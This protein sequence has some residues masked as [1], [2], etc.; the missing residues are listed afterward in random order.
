MIHRE[1]RLFA[2]EEILNALRELPFYEGQ[3][4][5]A[6]C[7]LPREAEYA[8]PE[9]PMHPVLE[10]RL[11]EIGIERLYSHQATAFDLATAKKDIVVTTGTGSG[12][13][14]CYNLPVLHALLSEP[15]AKALYLFPTKALA[16][17]QLGKLRELTPP[18][19][20]MQTYDGDTPLS[21]R[22]SIRKKAH[23]IL[24]NPDMLHVGI[25][26][27][28]TSWIKFL[29]NLRF[30]VID[31]L[32]AYSGVFGSHVAL[33]ISRLLRLCAWHGNRPQII[34]CSASIRNP[35]ELFRS[36]TGR[37]AELVD[38]DGSPRGIRMFVFWN[39]PLIGEG[40]RRSS[41]TETARLMSALVRMGIRALVFSQSR[42]AA[43]L[44]LSYA[45]KE[46]EEE[47]PALSKVVE[48]YRGGYTPQ[49]RREIERRLFHGD[50]FALS[51]TNAMELGVDIGSL[52]AAVINGYPGSVSSLRQQAGRAGRG[53]RDGL[54]IFIARDDPLEQFLMRHPE[55]ALEG[56]A[57]SV[58]VHPGN[59]YVLAPHLI[60]AAHERPISVSELE[61]F[62][63][64]ALDTLESL[65]K[66]GTL[67]R[68]SGMWFF[69]QSESPASKINLRS[70]G[71]EF[72]IFS[73][74][75]VLGSLEEWRAYH[76]AHEGAI[77][78]HRGENYLVKELDL[79]AGKVEVENVVADYYTQS[80]VTTSVYPDVEIRR[81]EFSGGGLTFL[82]LTVTNT[83]DGY[84]KKSMKTNEVL[85]RE[86]LDLPP[87][88]FQTLGLCFDIHCCDEGDE[89]W[90]CGVHALEHLLVALAP[91]V[92][93]CEPRDL[94]SAYYPFWLPTAS[95]AIFVFDSVPGGAG[96][97]EALYEEAEDWIAHV[98]EQLANCRCREGCPSCIFSPRCPYSNQS[99][100]KPYAQRIISA[101]VK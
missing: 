88:S 25:L 66:E 68:R 10:K 47:A 13:T 27:N 37:D 39:P 44:V 24:S 81:K 97:C 38:R 72:T 99:L 92:A 80:L 100:S 28:H 51:T 65:E 77:Y 70:S 94:G 93:R 71:R 67:E 40:Y 87:Y 101:L 91:V 63:P 41:I 22:A 98:Q 69:P 78:M 45:R 19:I 64:Q 50:L 53:A 3:I 23:I 33:V 75:E 17:D 20:E 56:K 21:E 76:S 8:E 1:T 58:R 62:P 52:D 2:P 6:P 59:P 43:E 16:Q 79:R 9:R 36:L 32:H 82:G 74:G 60:C 30:I 15:A 42:I 35:L 85:A 61:V 12:K 29:K 57:E 73:E 49:E 90:I 31:E 89:N 4:E 86:G 46:L 54:A 34:A 48:S 26:P 7:T 55:I 83:V 95:P 18:G 84:L 5:N 96:I 11:R 14:L